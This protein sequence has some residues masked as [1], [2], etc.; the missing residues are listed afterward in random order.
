[1][2]DFQVGSVVRIGSD[3]VKIDKYLGIVHGLP[4]Y[5]VVSVN[6][7]MLSGRPVNTWIARIVPTLT[8]TGVAGS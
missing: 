1:M 3:E 6:V 2:S 5:R 8:I 4:T 7:R